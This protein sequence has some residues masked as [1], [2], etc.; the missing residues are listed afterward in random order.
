MAMNIDNIV[1]IGMPGSGKS[2]IGVLLA[3]TVLYDFIDT[4]IVIQNICKKTLCDIINKEGADEFLK[5]ENRILSEI[6]AQKTVIATGGSAVYGEAAMKNLKNGGITVYLRLDT[7]EIKRRIDNINTR[8]VVMEKGQT[9]ESLFLE[10]NPLYEKY[11]DVTVDCNGLTPEQ[12]VE[13]IIEYIKPMLP[14]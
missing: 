4:D 3:K 11:A 12:C 8:G 9:I 2:T 7:D 1:L 5:T 10:R 13:K 14:I 6:S